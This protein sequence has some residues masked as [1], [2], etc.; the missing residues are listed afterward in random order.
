[1]AKRPEKTKFDKYPHINLVPVTLETTGRPGKHAR[2]FIS[3]LMRD[4]DN[5][6]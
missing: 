4:A 3:N 6:H 5:R 1:M 2:K